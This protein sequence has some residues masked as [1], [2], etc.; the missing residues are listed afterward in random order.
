LI[1]TGHAGQAVK[2]GMKDK[3][4][5]RCMAAIL[6]LLLALVSVSAQ[7]VAS[8]SAKS[9]PVTAASF[10][11][12]SELVLV[13]VLVNDAQGKHISRLTKED[14]KVKENGKAQN[15]SFVEEIKSR[16]ASA[17][18]R[19]STTSDTYTNQTQEQ[20]PLRIVIILF[21]ML[22]SHFKDQVPARRQVVTFLRE[23]V[24]P[25][26]LVCVMGLGRGGL[27]MY[28]DLTS[29]A[30]GLAAAL[31]LS[32]ASGRHAISKLDIGADE[33]TTESAS[34]QSFVGHGQFALTGSS[35]RKSRSFIVQNTLDAFRNIAGA[36]AGVPGRKSMIWVTGGFPLSLDGYKPGSMPGLD[37][38]SLV[39]MLPLYERTWQVLNDA[40]ISLYPVDM[41]GLQNTSAPDATYSMRRGGQS[42]RQL[43]N[44]SNNRQAKNADTIGTL[45]TFAG[46]TGGKAFY[47]DNDLVA[48]L[49]GAVSDSES[50]YLVG[51]YLRNG[52]TSGW[53]KLT[54]EVSHPGAHVRARS[55]FFVMR[56]D[57]ANAAAADVK[58]MDV[59]LA[60]SSPMNFT[61]V[62]FSVRWLGNGPELKP[63]S[64]STRT[65]KRTVGF[66]I[67]LP[68]H[69]TTIDEANQN[70]IAL[71]FFGIART[72]AA[73]DVADFV[74]K[75]DGQLKPEVA[76][77]MREAG[78][79]FDSTIELVPGRYNVRFVVRD[80]LSGRV[81]S[82]TAPV[83]VK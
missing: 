12:R 48:G 6:F 52:A 11:S 46:M 82:V 43:A 17:I 51:Y 64:V 63:D 22:N 75:M 3:I 66:Q 25:G 65:N 27:R 68:A 10:S 78:L 74:K 15:V 33:D 69:T 62:P 49:R 9:G 73:T 79:K 28:H 45:Q 29:D 4:T 61:G 24:D 76:T 32:A 2:T 35:G 80:N 39:D 57:P 36:Y 1:E 56:H 53:H 16:P 81:G 42:S 38:D 71:S 41:H 77:R 37:K 55:G 30:K 26:T 13:P 7:E 58:D 60:M 21:D 83:T 8:S 67:I 34:A 31:E 40:N 59:Q 23:D 20:T 54:V 50:S 47:N 14:F 70:Q 44:Y 72:Q 5:N 19:A 18:K